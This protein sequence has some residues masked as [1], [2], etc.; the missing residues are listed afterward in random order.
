MSLE[1]ATVEELKGALKLAK[2]RSTMTDL[3]NQ[4]GNGLVEA[5]KNARSL[6]QKY[7]TSKRV[8]NVQ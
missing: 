5:V 6:V 3:E 4:Y 1:N 2:A 8:L 7:D